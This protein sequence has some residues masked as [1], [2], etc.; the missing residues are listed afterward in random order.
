MEVAPQ[1]R[2][3][4]GKWASE[5]D[6]SPWTPA[7]P[8]HPL[9]TSVAGEVEVKD[10]GAVDAEVVQPVKVGLQLPTGQLRLQQQG[11]MAEDKGIQGGRA[12]ETGQ[13]GMQVDSCAGLSVE[14]EG[15]SALVG[16]ALGS[17][18]SPGGGQGPELW[19]G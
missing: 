19:T 17:K 15:K 5:A 1:L 13:G 4:E 14:Q 7:H 10:V 16:W 6:P 3:K 9:P 12:A 18:G 2:G 11:Q 8:P